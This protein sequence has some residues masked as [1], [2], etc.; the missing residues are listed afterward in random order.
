VALSLTD[1]CKCQD[2]NAWRRKS[3]STRRKDARRHNGRRIHKISR[4][5]A[6]MLNGRER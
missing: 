2:R 1:P 6:D 5:F 3:T 4:L